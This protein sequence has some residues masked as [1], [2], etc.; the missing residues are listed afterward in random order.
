MITASSRTIFPPTSD[1]YTGEAPTLADIAQ[2]M[3]RIA[4]F[5]G[6]TREYWTVLAHTF[7]G[8]KLMPAEDRIHFLLHDAAEPV[9]GDVVST[10]K[11]ALSKNDEAHILELI[12]DDLGID[13]PTPDQQQVVKAVDLARLAAE[14]H[15]LGHAQ[16]EKWWPRDEWSILEFR[17]EE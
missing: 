14:A 13:M 15:V 3:G 8:A 6:Q 7:V 12:Y 16:A 2:G 10:W 9:I 11:N 1:Y 5:A 4:R 17:A